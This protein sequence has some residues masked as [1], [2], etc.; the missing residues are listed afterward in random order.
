MKRAQRSSSGIQKIF[1]SYSGA[2]RKPE[3]Q[4]AP[5]SFVIT[6]PKFTAHTGVVSHEDQKGEISRKDV[7]L[8]LSVPKHI[9]V[10]L[11]N[12]LLEERKIQKSGMAKSSSIFY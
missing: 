3:I 6:L 11:L 1:E 9:A 7:E 8:N 4:P 10:K 5:A 12:E 2:P